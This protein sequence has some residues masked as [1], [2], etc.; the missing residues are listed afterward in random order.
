MRKLLIGT[1]LAAVLATPAFAADMIQNPEPA[2]APVVSAPAFSWTGFYVGGQLGYGWAKPDPGDD[3]GSFIGGLNAGYNHDFGGWVLGAEIDYSFANM[4]FGNGVGVDGLGAGKLKVGAALGRTLL[5][6]TGGVAYVRGDNSDSKAGYVVGAGV[7]Y[8]V[9]DNMF[10]GAE[11]DFNHFSNVDSD[12]V[13][14]VSS[15]IDV[16]EVTARVGWKF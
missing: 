1:A 5:Y 14:G 6:G 12:M 13:P 7:D 15:D 9:T 8:A 10:V 2:P 16:H 11:Y 3:D 4:N